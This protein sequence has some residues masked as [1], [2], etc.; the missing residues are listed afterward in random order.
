MSIRFI[1]RLSTNKM[2]AF[3]VVA[4]ACSVVTRDGVSGSARQF[5]LQLVQQSLHVTRG[6]CVNMA[7]FFCFACRFFFVCFVVN[8]TVIAGDLGHEFA[9]SA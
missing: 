6:V 9:Q 7:L 8:P 3:V 5:G 1:F 2:V 4:C